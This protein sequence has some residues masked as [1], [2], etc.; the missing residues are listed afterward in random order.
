MKMTL[1]VKPSSLVP[2]AAPVPLNR[3]NG[4]SGK[5]IGHVHVQRSTL[6]P[7]VFL[8]PRESLEAEAARREK[9]LV[10][11]ATSLRSFAALTRLKKNL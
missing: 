11:L 9:P 1:M 6:V 4:G 2:R 5:E 10:T 3:G 7:E 8:E